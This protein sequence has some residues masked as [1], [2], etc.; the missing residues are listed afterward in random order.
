MPPAQP[1]DWELKIHPKGFS[2]ASDEFRCTL[3]S[4]VILDQTRPVEYLLS[5]VDDRKILKSV[6]GKKIFSKTRCVLTVVSISSDKAL[7]HFRYSQDLEMD[8][9]VSVDEITAE[10]SPLLVNNNLVLQLTMRPIE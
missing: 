9:K 2:S 6:S 3:V 10:N 1:W 5:V 8:K 4:N 7:L